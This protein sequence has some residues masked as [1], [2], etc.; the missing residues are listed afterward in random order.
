MARHDRR[1]TVTALLLSMFMAAM[2]ATVVGTAM[3]TVIADLGGLSLYGWVGSAYLLAST[4]SVPVYGK[5]ADVYGRKPLLLFGIA[6]FL[7]G[8]L[9]SGGAQTIVTL[10]LARAVQGLGAGAMQPIATT[11]VG[12]LFAIEERGRVQGL[13]GAVWGGAAVAGPLLGGLIVQT[14]SW[15]WVFWVNVPFG[16]ASAALLARFFREAPRAPRTLP[17]DWLG[18][19]LLSL[20]ALSLLLGAAG[21]WPALTL[22]LG[23]LFAL[24]VVWQGKRAADPVFPIA[25]LTRRPIAVATLTSLLLGATMMGTLMFVPLYMQGVLGRTPSEAGATAAPMLLGWPIASSLTSR[26]LTRVGFRA[27]VWLGSVFCA[28]GLL[29]FALLLRPGA[30]MLGLQAVMFVYGLGM[31]L[32]NTTLLI[33]V[34]SS[35]GWEQR[36]VATATTMFSRSIGGAL[37]VG[38]FG[39]VL[40]LRLGA[41]LPPDSVRAILDPVRRHAL[42]GGAQLAGALASSLAPIFWVTAALAVLNVLVV[43]FYPGE[44]ARPPPERPAL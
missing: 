7:V 3:P 37:G 8:S 30:G 35:V 31:G 44:A 16:L 32:V 15:R 10:I 22:P 17:L 9:A 14:L 36:G 23:A 6:L 39:S 34:Q 38:A 40:A 21:E 19:L 41:V 25:L 18:A 5:L 42:V 33:A 27:P 11:V 28:V 12:D 4:V 26:V 2:E 13:I 24:L 20:A 29:A 43:A 1:L